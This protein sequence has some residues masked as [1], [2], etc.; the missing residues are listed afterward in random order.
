MGSH[1]LIAGWRYIVIAIT[2][3]FLGV[4]TEG[5]EGY[6]DEDGIDDDPVDL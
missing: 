4:S 3:R 6:K 5:S 2:R 1:I